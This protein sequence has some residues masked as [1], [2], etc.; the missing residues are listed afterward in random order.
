M[1]SFCVHGRSGCFPAATC[2]ADAGST[3]RRQ[4]LDGRGVGTQDESHLLPQCIIRVRFLAAILATE[5]IGCVQKLEDEALVF[6]G[7]IST[8]ICKNQDSRKEVASGSQ[9]S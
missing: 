9:R 2:L 6:L 8:V 5:S 3:T 4:C 1:H 7:A